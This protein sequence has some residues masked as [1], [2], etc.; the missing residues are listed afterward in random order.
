MK[1]I[2][3]LVSR[4][5]AIVGL[6]LI[7]YPLFT[8]IVYKVTQT[9]VITKY[10]NNVKHM[11]TTEIEETN[12]KYNEYNNDIY[13]N[14]RSNID[15]SKEGK[16]LGYINIPKININYA[17]YEGTS[18]DVLTKGIGHLKNTSIPG[19][20][21]THSVLAG[22]TGLSNAKM[23]DDLDKL[24]IKDIFSISILNNCYN[25]EVDDIKIVKKD[26]MQEFKI[27]EGKEYVTLITCT[28]RFINSHR[29]L[30]R[31]KRIDD[32]SKIIIELNKHRFKI[33]R[34][35]KYVRVP[36][37]I[38]SIICLIV[39]LKLAK[40]K[41]KSYI[42]YKGK[43]MIDMKKVIILILIILL[44][45]SLILF[46]VYIK[47][48]KQNNMETLSHDNYE[49][50]NLENTNNELESNSFS[51]IVIEET[52]ESETN[53]KDE[54]NNENDKSK[55]TKEDKSKISKK[56]TKSTDSKTTSKKS[57]SNSST[58]KSQT[59]VSSK[60]KSSSK[61]TKKSS[62]KKSVTTKKKNTTTNKSSKSK[63]EKPY[64]CYEGGTHHFAGDDEY[65]HGYYKT[66]DE[67]WEACKKYMKDMDSGNYKVDECFCGLYY[68]YVKE[69]K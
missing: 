42:I 15:L 48:I 32:N 36:L 56:T 13:K 63:T 2:K 37:L 47:K 16:I 28:P 53:T 7:I 19:Q 40:I 43:G 8:N 49:Q 21:N 38:I 55:E 52:N 62:S 68:F 5:L 17:I 12:K 26:D 25:Y 57:A 50:M 22:H 51:N 54:K 20:K 60:K 67:A 34:E 66:W 69:K 9:K 4:L 45:V 31:G 30:V 11:T 33:I 39:F 10:Q 58:T 61:T 3:K 64:W 6:I 59:K 18:E 23:F 65:E 35:I 27:E 29:L 24:K 46:G 1:K 41:K 44:I 14:A